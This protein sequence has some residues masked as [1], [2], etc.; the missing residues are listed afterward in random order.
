MV[1][2]NFFS[3]PSF[4]PPPSHLF[5]NSI[6]SHTPDITCMPSQASIAT[7]L[8]RSV[9]P[10]LPSQWLLGSQ[11]EWTHV[12]R[13]EEGF[14]T[15]LIC[16]KGKKAEE[17]DPACAGLTINWSLWKLSWK[18]STQNYQEMPGTF[19]TPSSFSP[20]GTTCQSIWHTHSHKTAE[21]LSLFK[22]NL[23]QPLSIWLPRK[24]TVQSFCLPVPC[25]SNVSIGW[26][27]SRK[28]FQSYSVPTCFMKVSVWTEDESLCHK[29]FLCLIT[30]IWKRTCGCPA[31]SWAKTSTFSSVKDFWVFIWSG[32]SLAR[33]TQNCH[34]SFSFTHC[35]HISLVWK[36]VLGKCEKRR[37]IEKGTYFWVT[38]AMSALHPDT[39]NTAAVCRGRSFQN[40]KD[41][42]EKSV[43]IVP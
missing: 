39:D 30:K 42:L 5:P 20:T 38:V 32:K 24:M 31:L 34:L 17:E 28:M 16:G 14:E 10:S 27:I 1:F 21:F 36:I 25:P 15:G 19:Q 22:S 4:L 37:K 41:Y 35:W 29:K 8:S 9:F 26:P 3:I 11:T 33:P 40:L 23:Q 12:Q 7:L 6:S 2:I 18:N 43:P 13:W